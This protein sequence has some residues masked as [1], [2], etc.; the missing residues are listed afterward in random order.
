MSGRSEVA[1]HLFPVHVGAGS[2]RA[3][4]ADL[5]VVGAGLAGLSVA[6]HYQQLRPGHRVLVVDAGDVGAGASGRATGLLGPRVGPG[7]VANASR[8]G[9]STA[10]R[11]FESSEQAVR[12]V[13][14]LARAAAA[15]VGLQEGVQWFA[16]GARMRRL[17][18]EAAAYERWG[19]DVSLAAPHDLP[20]PLAERGCGAL[21]FPR[22]ATLST[23][24]FTR[25]LA[26]KARAAGAELHLQSPV[27]S[28]QHGGTGLRAE[29]DHGSVEARAVVLATNGLARLAA[30]QRG[31]TAVRVHATRTQQLSATEL[32]AVGIGSGDAVIGEGFASYYRLTPAQELIVGAGVPHPG[33]CGSDAPCTTARAAVRRAADGLAPESRSTREDWAGSIA[34]TLDQLPVV[35]E[36]APATYVVGGWN[37]HGLALSVMTGR[38]VAVALCGGGVPDLPWWRAQVSSALPAAT[39]RHLVKTYLSLMRRVPRAA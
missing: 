30:P 29:L 26:S 5:V 9:A 28:V 27:R 2:R 35:G 18:Q 22:T 34:V 7:A 10:H 36:V 31:L 33:P 32:E 23:P 37:G 38:D 15:E 4:R 14:D 13:L 1:T 17:Q 6:W 21:L 20:A 11:M 39:H 16:A 24:A 3:Q 25:L 8:F 12:L 19:T